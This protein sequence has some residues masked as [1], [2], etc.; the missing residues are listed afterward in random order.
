MAGGWWRHSRVGLWF[1]LSG[2]RR[3]YVRNNDS[4]YNIRGIPTFDHICHS[5]R[6]IWIPPTYQN[7]NHTDTSTP[8]KIGQC[9]WPSRPTDSDSPVL[10][11]VS[12]SL[13]SIPAAW[14]YAKASGTMSICLGLENW[15][16]IFLSLETPAFNLDASILTIM[17][18]N[19]DASL[20]NRIGYAS[21]TSRDGKR[22]VGAEWREYWRL[23]SYEQSYTQLP[24]EAKGEDNNIKIDV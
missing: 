14:A 16:K 1:M 6:L 20:M 24:F 5:E 7:K 18:S 19:R 9:V 21:K 22:T 17:S 13:R 2:S 8:Y 4:A 15:T 11:Y 3:V 12:S 10:T 23:I